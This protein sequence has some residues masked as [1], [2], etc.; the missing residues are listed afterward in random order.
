[1]IGND[2]NAELSRVGILARLSAYVA[3]ALRYW[4]PRRLIYN[5]VL[6]IVVVVHAIA[7]WPESRAQLTFDSLLGAFILAVLAN[8]AYCAVWSSLDFHPAKLVLW[9]APRIHRPRHRQ[10]VTVGFWR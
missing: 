5:A 10:E 4:E 1:M 2:R 6:A 9:L 7:A 8:I 3:N